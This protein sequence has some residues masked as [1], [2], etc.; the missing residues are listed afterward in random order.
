MIE[1]VAL[2]TIIKIEIA[3]MEKIADC[4]FVSHGF[5]THNQRTLCIEHIGTAYIEITGKTHLPIGCECRKC[6]EIRSGT[7]DFPDPVTKT[8]AAAMQIVNTLKIRLDFV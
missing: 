6:Y 2:A 1:N 3:V 8:F 4:R 5:K 7:G